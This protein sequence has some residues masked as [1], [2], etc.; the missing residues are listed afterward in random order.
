[1]NSVVVD[2]SALLPAGL[3]RAKAREWLAEDVPNIDI[4]GFVVG[5]KVETAHLLCKGDG[6]LAGVPFA[7]AVFDELGLEVEWKFAEGTYIDTGSGKNKVICAVVRGKC[8]DILLSERTALNIISR[9]SGVA[10]ASRH[11]MDIA[12]REN[13]HGAVAGT[14][15]TTPGFRC[16]EKYAL[17]VGGA[18]T[19]R[20][21]LSQMVMLK[22]NHIWSAGSITAAVR[23]ARSAAGFSMKIEVECQSVKEAVE[24]ATAGADVVMLDNF[25]PETIHAAAAEIKLQ[26]PNVTLE[27]S[28]GISETSMHLYMG[29]HI[30]V[31][32]RGGLTHGYP[33]IDFSL[34]VQVAV[35]R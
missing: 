32:S 34:K 18:A 9:A 25:T 23:K 2:H 4:G 6:C 8:K 35:P 29:P 33:C 7:Q 30:D 12:R 11:A 17:L 31:I 21:D 27:A 20:Q 1:M 5:E 26:C 13:W 15:K 16:V 10:T 3:C 19:H 24:A 22:D 28:G 14:R